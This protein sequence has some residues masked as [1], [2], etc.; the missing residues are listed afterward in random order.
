M[1]AVWAL[2][3][4]DSEKIVL[5]A[6]ADCANDEGH[7][8]PSM[9]TLATKCSK[10]DRTVQA[11]IK[12]LVDGGHLTRNEVPGKGCNY[13]IHPRSD[14]PPE[15]ASPPKPVRDTPEASG[16]TPPK[17]LRTNRKE[18]SR[19]TK[20]IANAI[21]RTSDFEIPAWVPAEPWAAY[22]AMRKRKKAPIDSYIAGKQFTKLEKMAAEGWDIAKVLDKATLNNWTDLYTPTPGRDDEMRANAPANG[23]HAKP[24]NAADRAAYLAKLNDSPM[25]TSTRQAP[26]AQRQGGTGPP[27]P[28]GELIQHATGRA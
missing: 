4:A 8:W 19:T 24:M 5:L 25:F 13:T 1:T 12:A 23:N 21:Q 15:A 27:R 26:A 28:I 9:A 18:P 17:P 20:R 10:T 2:K 16:G 11:A 6:L 14:F 22:S 3:L 7:C